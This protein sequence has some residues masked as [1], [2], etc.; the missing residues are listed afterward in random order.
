MGGEVD[1]HELP[2]GELG[3]AC[4]G[5]VAVDGHLDVDQAAGRV[6]IGDLNAREESENPTEAQGSLTRSA[7]RSGDAPPD[8]AGGCLTGHLCSV[9]RDVTVVVIAAGE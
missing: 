7:A 6:R 5:V 8:R 4:R 1:Q 2:C 3:Q 9:E